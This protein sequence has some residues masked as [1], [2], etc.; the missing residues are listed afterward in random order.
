MYMCMDLKKNTTL[1]YNTSS[2]TKKVYYNSSAYGMLSLRLNH[3]VWPTLG[4]LAPRS[5]AASMTS[6]EEARL[7]FRD[8]P[9][10]FCACRDCSEMTDG[11]LRLS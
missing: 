5:P 4:A 9:P 10:V 2:L 8:T 11:R 3:P 6:G 1:A 7:G